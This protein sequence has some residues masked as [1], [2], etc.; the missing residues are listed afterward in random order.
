MFSIAACHGLGSDTVD[1]AFQANII[2]PIDVC[3]VAINYR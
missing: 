2:E 1:I 3:I